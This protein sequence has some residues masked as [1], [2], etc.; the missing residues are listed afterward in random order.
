LNKL[1]VTR[2]REHICT[3]LADNRTIL[4]INLEPE[5]SGTLLDN[6]YVGKVQNIKKNINSAFVDIGGGV[7]GYYSMTD[8]PIPIFAGV[9]PSG[10]ISY[11]PSRPASKLK[12]GD[13]IIVQV[14][15]DAV[16]T[17]SLVLTSRL[18]LTGKLAVV[19]L[20][21]PGVGFS[22]KIH[23]SAW[24]AEIRPYLQ[25]ETENKFSLIA[26]T[27]AKDASLEELLEEVRRLK[28][29]LISI[30]S[31]ASSRKCY[32]LLYQGPSA[33]LTGIRNAYADQ[34]EEIVTDDEQLF[35]QI[36]EFLQQHQPEDEKKL[37]FYQDNLLSLTKLYSLEK[38]MEECLGKR[39]WLKSGGYLVIEPTEALVVID[40]NT[41]K[42]SEKK[43]VQ[44]TILKINLEAAEEIARQLRLR[45]L[46]GIILVDF[47]DMEEDKH[48]QLLLEH[49]EKVVRNDP[50]KTNVVD[51]TR[52]NLVELTRK[53]IQ[54]PL[55]EQLA[56]IAIK[57]N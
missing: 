7:T 48:K 29:Q 25:E 3:A 15:K 24:K 10:G 39:V 4:Q 6:I 31:R 27:N 50:I 38:I 14:A 49:L 9:S 28:E 26:R 18:T 8:N 54:R 11:D 13:E 57:E 22:S 45:N 41:G 16:K 5:D 40:V 46:S 53:K 35:S 43:T 32:S 17:K 44:E 47:I 23:S 21:K 12:A 56:G 51:I 34:L 37:R 52:L 2:W 42:Y 55:Y 33:F 30:L 19:T 20:G 1:I 36:R